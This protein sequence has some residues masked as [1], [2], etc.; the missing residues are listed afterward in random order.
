MRNK[1]WVPD[2]T[3]MYSGAI[4][5]GLAVTLV[6]VGVPPLLRLVLWVYNLL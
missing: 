6:F 4:L 5:L 2:P 1:D 3:E